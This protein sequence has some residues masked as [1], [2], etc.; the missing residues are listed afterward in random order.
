[1]GPLIVN[2]LWVIDRIKKSP[3]RKSIP[4][5]FYLHRFYYCFARRTTYFLIWRKR[6]L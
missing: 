2:Q 1:M 6:F 3:G 4:D 5:F